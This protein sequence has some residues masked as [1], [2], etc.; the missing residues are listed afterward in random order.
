MKKV[1][2][3]GN[4][5]KLSPELHRAIANLY[6][7][8]NYTTEN[9]AKQYSV[10]LKTIQR[11]AKKFGVIRDQAT[12]NKLMAKHKRYHTIPIE[13]RVKRKQITQKLRYEMLTNQPY[14][15]LCGLPA[16][17]GIR[18][19]IDHIDENP[20]NNNLNNLQV[21]CR[22]CNTGKSHIARFGSSDVQS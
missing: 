16:G 2:Y 10:S 7:S 8:G 13:L 11:I 5:K 20:M 14:C 3:L 15:T 19:E 1:K 6:A 12:A 9:L 21:L 17:K 22:N 4:Y 18:L